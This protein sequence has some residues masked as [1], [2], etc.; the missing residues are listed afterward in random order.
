MSLPNRFAPLFIGSEEST[1]VRYKKLG[2]E[3]YE[4]LDPD[5]QLR[6]VR[7]DV[8]VRTAKGLVDKLPS[9]LRS[10]VATKLETA[11]ALRREWGER[12]TFAP[13]ISQNNH[14]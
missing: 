5:G 1:Y 11:I 14:K 4:L 13:L 7:Y 8:A 2:V 6:N 3:I 10:D 12:F 9:E